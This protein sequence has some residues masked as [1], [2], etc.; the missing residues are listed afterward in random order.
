M[1]Y[2][3]NQA[4]QACKE[5]PSLVFELIKEGYIE[6]VDKVLSLKNFD[7]NVCDNNGNNVLMRLLKKG[8]YDIVLKHM[9]NK[10]FDI[11]HQN[12]D[13]DTFAHLL[14]SINY[15]NII[16]IIKQLR[17]NKDF[18]P[19]IKNMNG[20]TILDKSINDNYIYTTVKILE[21]KRFN[22][23]DIFSFKNLYET[24][25]KTNKYGKYTKLTNLEII[26]DN[27]NEKNLLPSMERLLNVLK[28]NFDYIKEEVFNNKTTIIDNTIS[29]IMQEA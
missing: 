7:I 13:G 27:L 10:N 26:M 17:K 8:S 28:E 23:I 11:N 25:I 1:F 18:L 22:N 5:E 2:D 20:E 12:N 19:N 29:T 6:V 9:K 16:E 21:D 14:V 4:I 3:E 24:Y 15:V